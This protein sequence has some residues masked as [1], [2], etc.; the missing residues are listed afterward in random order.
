MFNNRQNA[1]QE[2][3]ETS[4]VRPTT[5]KVLG[6]GG[7]GCNTVNRMIELGIKGVD[8]IC[9]NTD[10]QVLKTCLAPQ[11]ILLGPKVTRGQGAGGDP[12]IGKLAA[13]ESANELTAALAGSDMVFL[14]AG[15]GGGTGTGAISVAADIA[16][17]LGIVTVAVVSLPFGFEAGTRQ[18]NARTGLNVLRQATDTLI[19]IPNDRLLQVTPRDLPLDLAFRVADD[20][21]RQGIQGISEIIAVPGMINVDF[22]HIR[23]MMRNG[24]GSILAIGTGKGNNKAIHAVQQ[25]LHHP[26]LDDI[27]IES[28]TGIIVNITG[29]KELTFFEVNEALTYLQESAKNQAEIIPGIINDDSMGDRVEVILI[30]T[31]LGAT[32]FDPTPQQRVPRNA[33][34]VTAY[35]QPVWETNK[36][37]AGKAST[38]ETAA[39]YNPGQSYKKEVEMVGSTT[40]LDVPAFMRK[41]IR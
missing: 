15:L 20:V 33:E 1:Y 30:L 6:L 40:N 23:N 25:A 9:A 4:P 8:F 34:Q 2:K 36:D 10:L 21:L 5:L 12:Q 19:A 28:A 27:P 37:E 16:K 26:L 7:G 18:K 17:K 13:E 35:S 41:R 31:G 38:S 29:G 32:A 11:K 14:T 22:S 24:G 3:K 39:S